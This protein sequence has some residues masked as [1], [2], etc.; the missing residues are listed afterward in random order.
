MHWAHPPSGYHSLNLLVW[1]LARF[2]GLDARTRGGTRRLLRCTDEQLDQ[3]LS[4]ATDLG[5]IE[6]RGAS[7]R[8][9]PAGTRLGAQTVEAV[10]ESRAR[11]RR[12][13]RPYEGY[14]PREWQLDE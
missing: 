9:T 4:D 1:A 13:Y 12:P 11:S 6:Q 3:L 5:L 10:Q 2:G 14:L 8:L 7:R